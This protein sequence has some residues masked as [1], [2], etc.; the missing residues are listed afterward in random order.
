MYYNSVKEGGRML[1]Y[2]VQCGRLREVT[3]GHTIL[4]T[5][6][7]RVTGTDYPLAVCLKCHGAMD[8]LCTE[9]CP[10]GTSEKRSALPEQSHRRGQKRDKKDTRQAD[11]NWLGI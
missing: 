9:K 1:A 3:D 10:P 2:C 6:F 8:R 11:C 5:A 4:K 7:R